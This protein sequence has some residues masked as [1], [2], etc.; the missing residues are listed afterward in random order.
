MDFFKSNKSISKSI[1]LTEEL[2]NYIDGYHGDGFNQKFENIILDAMFTEAERRKKLADLNR[3][4][5]ALELEFESKQK[6]VQFLVSKARELG[7]EFI[8]F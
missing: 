8:C 6:K 5:S 2:Y 3:Q 7:S 1:R 4:I